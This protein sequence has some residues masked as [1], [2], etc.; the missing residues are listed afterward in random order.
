[1]LLP[2]ESREDKKKP[3]LILLLLILLLS[4][5]LV[6]LIQILISVLHIVVPVYGSGAM[7]AISPPWLTGTKEWPQSNNVNVSEWPSQD[8]GLVFI[9]L[10][11]LILDSSER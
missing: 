1:M 2:R 10:P 7:H 5:I 6:Q 4:V 11:S 8:P 3:K 9:K